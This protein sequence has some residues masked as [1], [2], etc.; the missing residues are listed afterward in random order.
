MKITSINRA[1]PEAVTND[2]HLN[3]ADATEVAVS[4]WVGACAQGLNANLNEPLNARSERAKRSANCLVIALRLGT[5]L[6]TKLGTGLGTGRFA[7][8]FGG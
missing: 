2:W 8:F 6:R 5:R 4:T 3:G 1:S 7:R